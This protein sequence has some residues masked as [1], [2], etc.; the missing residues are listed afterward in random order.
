MKG[1][2]DMHSAGDFVMCMADFNEYIGRHIGG[3]YRIN[4][5]VWHRSVQF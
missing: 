4:G 3:F 5:R 2:L 1:E